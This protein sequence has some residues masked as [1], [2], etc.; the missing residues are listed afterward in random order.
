MSKLI[1][2]EF[3]FGNNN[4]PS[5]NGYWGSYFWSPIEFPMV[6]VFD[7]GE[8]YTFDRFYKVDAD[9]F[10]GQFRDFEVYVAK[11]YAGADTKWKL[12]CK[13]KTGDKGWQRYTDT[14][15]DAIPEKPEAE[16]SEVNLTRARYIKLCITASSKVSSK[17]CGYLM[18]F[19][20]DGWKM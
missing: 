5:K 10:Q 9:T 20:A 19:Y 7:A 11:E 18:E 6:F 15:I 17:D 3:G 14:K 13:G 1:D 4:D 8:I 12:A 16:G 2:W